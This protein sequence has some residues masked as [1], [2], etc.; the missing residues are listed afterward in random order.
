MCLPIKTILVL[1]IS[2]FSLPLLAQIDTV[3]ICEVGDSVHLNARPGMSAYQW[4]AEDVN[5]PN[6]TIPNPVVFPLQPSLLTVTM[7]PEFTAENLIENPG[8]EEG[9]IGFT[10]DY[11]YGVLVTAPGL[12]GVS[13]SAEILNHLYFS[14]C[15]DHTSSE[16]QMLVVDGSARENEKVWCQV[17]SIEP[18]KNYAFSAWITSVKRENPARLQFSINGEKLGEPFRASDIVC[19]WRQFFELWSSENA[20]EA[21]ICI[22]NQN[23]NP[24]GNDFALD[25]FRFYELPEVLRDSTMVLIES[26]EAAKRRRGYFPN[27]FSPNFD[28]RNDT[29]R[30]YFDKGVT[31]LPEFR[32][33]DRW[34]NLV[35]SRTNCEPN[36]PDCAW[37]GRFKGKPMPI[38]TYLYLAKVKFADGEIFLEK[39][40]LQL[41]R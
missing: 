35:F 9:N 4:E 6:P 10:S 38:G 21:E 18:D 20:T 25:D 39:G 1:L 28:G 33:F 12:Y 29:F 32:I 24:D 40:G 22:I 23:L 27:V 17:V 41:V 37:D 19:E 30:P 16:G 14:D 11:E 13:E 2:S 34:G 31:F 26:L 15:P 3:W 5:F 36:D 7:L 8:F